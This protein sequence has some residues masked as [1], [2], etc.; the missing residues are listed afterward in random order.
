[1]RR[2]LS[3]LKNVSLTIIVAS[4]ITSDVSERSPVCSDGICKRKRETGY[5]R[6]SV[7]KKEN[8]NTDRAKYYNLLRV[9][10]Q[11]VL[12]TSHKP[13]SST[14]QEFGSIPST[15]PSCGQLNKRSK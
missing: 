13:L 14:H 5:T 6:L 3:K 10:A 11:S 8:E 2:K 4:G 15:S 12:S 1:M 9:L 7:K